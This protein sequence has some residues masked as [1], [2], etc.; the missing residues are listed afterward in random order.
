MPC[1]GEEDC[2]AA[3]LVVLM[4][5]LCGGESIRQLHESVV[6]LC[7]RRAWRTSCNVLSQLPSLLR[8]SCVSRRWRALIAHPDHRRKLPQTLAGFFYDTSTRCF[9][10]VSGTGS[11]LVD[12]LLAFLPD[13]ERKGL[14]LLDGCNGLLLCRCFRFA[15]QNVF[16]YLVINPATQKWVPVPV[17]RRWSS[18]VETARLGFEPAVSPHFYVFE[19][20]LDWV[21]DGNGYTQDDDDKDGHVLG[22]EIYS[23]ENRVWIQKQSS[24]SVEV[25]LDNEFKSVFVNG[26]LYMVATEAVIGAVDVEGKTWRIIDFPR[27]EDSTFLNTAP[28]YIDMSQGKLH[29]VTVDDITGNKQAVW[30]LEDLNSEEWTLKHTVSFTHLVGQQFVLFGFFEYNVVAVHPDRN[31]VFFIFDEDKTLISYDM[32]SGKVCVI[33]KLGRDCSESYCIPYVPLLSESMADGQH[34]IFGSASSPHT[35]LSDVAIKLGK[36]FIYHQIS[37]KCL[38]WEHCVPR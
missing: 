21:G 12:P 5:T 9:V 38:F 26:M 6:I 1:A 14:D 18:K 28:G 23:S 20:Q 4:I 17:S 35:N 3:G 27:S 10:N 2:A 33:R 19:F 31:M 22:V 16:D 34:M 24:W 7:M 29:L 11:P 30:V 32:D 15:D 25:T 8:C 36:G 37:W 13:R